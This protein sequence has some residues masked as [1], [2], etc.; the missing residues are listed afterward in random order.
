MVTRPELGVNQSADESMTAIASGQSGCARCGGATHMHAISRKHS[1]K[2]D[3]LT[4]CAPGWPSAPATFASQRAVVLLM[5]CSSRNALSLAAQHSLCTSWACQPCSPSP[6]HLQESL[7]RQER[8]FNP[9]E[10]E[11]LLE[12]GE[13]QPQI[14]CSVLERQGYAA[15]LQVVPSEDTVRSS[16]CQQTG[17]AC[18][19]LR[20]SSDPA[21]N[22]MQSIWS[23]IPSCC[24]LTN[25]LP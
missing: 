4:S 21:L 19:V 1:S 18:A 23:C 16:R 2:Q 24:I 6:H 15:R 14:Q 20:L 17:I 8:I 10:T 3:P 7:Q 9:L 25:N 22:G 11:A 13:S 5:P 12:E